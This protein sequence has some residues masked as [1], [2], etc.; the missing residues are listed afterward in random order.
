MESIISGIALYYALGVV[1][2]CVLGMTL[3]F[4]TEEQSF[5]LKP[6]LFFIAVL[7]WPLACPVCIFIVLA[8]L[9][10]RMLSGDE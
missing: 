1:V 6:K 5:F 9:F 4:I 7:L 8:I 3:F 2:T 10:F